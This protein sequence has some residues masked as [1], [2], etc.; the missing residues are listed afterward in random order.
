MAPI[1]HRA[2]RSTAMF[3]YQLLM[4]TTPP[5]RQ[6]PANQ[7]FR[8]TSRRP[9]PIRSWVRL[10]QLIKTVSRLALARPTRMIQTTQLRSLKTRLCHPLMVTRQRIARL[11]Q[12]ILARTRLLSTR[13]TVITVRRPMVVIP[14]VLVRTVIV[15]KALTVLL[16]VRQ[17]L[18]TIK[19]LMAIRV[20]TRTPQLNKAPAMEMLLVMAPTAAILLATVN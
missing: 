18:M 6:L 2:R 14:Q 1:G 17:P 4:V 15:V 10:F 19:M 12:S 16:M 9:F 5:K 3:R 13:R 8:R 20:L 7:R 11:H